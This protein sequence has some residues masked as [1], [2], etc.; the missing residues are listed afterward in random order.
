MR[1]PGLDP[2]ALEK[3]ARWV[4]PN[5]FAGWDSKKYPYLKLYRKSQ[6]KLLKRGGYLLCSTVGVWDLDRG[7]FISMAR[8]G[9]AY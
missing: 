9:V 7:A 5:G 3:L 6:P 2:A 8:G 1:L 4:S